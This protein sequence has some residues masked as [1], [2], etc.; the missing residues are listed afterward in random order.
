[1]ITVNH[2]RMIVFL[3]TVFFSCGFLSTP[4]MP[5]KAHS[6]ISKVAAA[7]CDQKLNELEEFAANHRVETNKTT[8][9]SEEEVNSY[10]SLDL[11]S[12]FH[13]SLKSLVLKFDEDMLQGIAAVDFDQLRSSSAQLLTK[14][15]STMF[16]GT[17]T[18]TVRGQLLSKNGKAHYQVEKAYFDDKEVPKALVEQIIATVGKRQN[19]PFNPLQP[20]ELPYEIRRAV[21]HPGQIVV[22]Q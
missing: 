7:R 17:H 12:Q 16:S 10:I 14:L 5:D 1:M 22:Y 11:S 8:R 20:S 6:S 15:V 9:F 19:P 4:M 18:I 13:P 2:C 3:L 21:V